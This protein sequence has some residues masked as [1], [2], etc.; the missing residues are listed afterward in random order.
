MRIFQELQCELNPNSTSIVADIERED[1]T[2]STFD[3]SIGVQYI[4]TT[5]FVSGI[6]CRLM[7]MPFRAELDDEQNE[8]KYSLWKMETIF[9]IGFVTIIFL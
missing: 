3:I 7:T 4:F 6:Y 2:K 5:N 9:E 8:I 1:I